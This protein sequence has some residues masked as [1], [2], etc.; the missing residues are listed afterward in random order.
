[1]GIKL[2]QWREMTILSQT[3]V[4]QGIELLN[5]RTEDDFDLEFD[6]TLALPPW[7]GCSLRLI[8]KRGRVHL[9]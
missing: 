5:S 2:S 7:L 6:N 8:S 4:T 1:M 3:N 9:V